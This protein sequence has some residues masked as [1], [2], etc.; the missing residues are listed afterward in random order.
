MGVLSGQAILARAHYLRYA[1]AARD[2][3]IGSA[4]RQCLE[5]GP[6]LADAEWKLT[7]YRSGV[8]WNLDHGPRCD[9]G[10]RSQCLRRQCTQLGGLDGTS[11]WRGKHY[12]E[13]V[14]LGAPHY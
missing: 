4:A 6:F 3:G 7:P 12:Y 13:P 5:V 14:D 9:A 2:A 10:L 11:G 1:R 8:G